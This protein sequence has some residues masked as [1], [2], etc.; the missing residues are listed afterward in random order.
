MNWHVVS[1]SL[2][3][4]CRIISFISPSSVAGTIKTLK[5]VSSFH[6]GCFF[7]FSLFL[8]AM[9]SFNASTSSGETQIA[10]SIIVMSGA[11]PRCGWNVSIPL[12]VLIVCV[13][14]MSN[15]SFS[16]TGNASLIKEAKTIPLAIPMISISI[17][18]LIPILS[19]SYPSG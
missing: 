12:I 4:T 5:F 1:F 6:F 7:F 2:S 15:F 19:S 3:R 16:L 8:A 17:L 9:S 11:P 14:L 10:L 13:L 18:A